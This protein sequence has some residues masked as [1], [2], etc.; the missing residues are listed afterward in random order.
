MLT[1]EKYSEH[2][3]KRGMTDYKMSVL[4]GIAKSTFSDWKHGKSTPKLENLLK[5]AKVLKLAPSELVNRED[6]K[7]AALVG[8]EDE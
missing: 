8:D 7:S 6:V 2:R 5:I 3:D 1:Y 4:T